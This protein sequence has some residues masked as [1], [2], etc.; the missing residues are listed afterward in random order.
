MKTKCKLK[1]DVLIKFTT[2]LYFQCL[3]VSFMFNFHWT[4]CSSYPVMDSY[5]QTETRVWW[6]KDAHSCLLPKPDQL[7]EIICILICN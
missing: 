1:I 3:K 2:Q 7:I 5:M 6:N 4:V